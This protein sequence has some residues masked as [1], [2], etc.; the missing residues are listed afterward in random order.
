[1]AFVPSLSW[2]MIVFMSLSWQMSRR[3]GVQK[4]HL[5]GPA[6]LIEPDSRSRNG[7]FIHTIAADIILLPAVNSDLSPVH[8]AC[9]VALT[10]KRTTFLSAFSMFVPSLSW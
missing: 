2:Q 10:K 9:A 7:L 8:N 1:M 3:K 6:E 4:S 5:C